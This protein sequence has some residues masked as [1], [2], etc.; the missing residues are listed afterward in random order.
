MAVG[1]PR[2]P[3]IKGPINPTI[4]K[5]GRGAGANHAN[6]NEKERTQ[7]RQSVRSDNESAEHERKSKN[8]MGKSDQPEEPPQ[9]A[10]SRLLASRMS[11]L[12]VHR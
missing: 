1:R 10:E 11:I 8:R 6:E 12:R 2:V 5:H 7:R 4:E 3:L 9:A